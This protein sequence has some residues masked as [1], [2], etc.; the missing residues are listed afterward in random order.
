MRNLSRYIIE[1]PRLFVGINIIITLFFGFFA[2]NIRV[3]DDIMN[4]LPEDDPVVETFNRISDT[5]GGSNIAVVILEADDIFTNEALLHIDHLT[6]LFAGV[7]GVTSVTSLTNAMDMRPEEDA[8]NVD[9]LVKKDYLYSK[10]ELEDL[11]K[12]VLGKELYVGSLITEDCRY[13]MILAKIDPDA[14]SAIVTTA[15]REIVNDEDTDS[16]FRHYRTGSAFVADDADRYAKGD[17]QRLL[18]T[19][20]LLVLLVLLLTFRTTRATLLPIATVLIAVIW[21]LGLLVLTGND[22]S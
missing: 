8:L 20:V 4:Y 21:T 16:P 19:V 22:L 14:D 6:D 1:H 13:S 18:P 12:Y 7:D 5:F 15:L 17:L 9:R 3:D 10:A 2:L 11:R